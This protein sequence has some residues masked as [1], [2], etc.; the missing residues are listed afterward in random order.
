MRS[1]ALTVAAQA[2]ERSRTAR[3]E[4]GGE[5]S[6]TQVETL[7]VAVRELVA[8]GEAAEARIEKLER[9]VRDLRAHEALT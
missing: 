3:R 1:E 2:V 8:F 9:R 7:E 6:M 5:V 4:R